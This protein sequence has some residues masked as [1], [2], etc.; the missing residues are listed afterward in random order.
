LDGLDYEVVIVDDDSDD[1]TAAAARHFAQSDSRI[2]VIQRINRRGLAV[3]LCRRNDG[4]GSQ[5]PGVMDSDLQHD[6]TIL[7]VM[8]RK[9][10]DE[11]LMSSLPAGTPGRQHGTFPGQRIALSKVGKR[12]G[13][14]VT[15]ADVSDLMSGFFVVDRRFLEE[16]VRSLSLTGFK[17]LLDMLA[18]LAGQ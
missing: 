3:G 1:G 16:V 5:L 7:P 10:K 15:H 14:L 6:E 8:L 9:L 17:I 11:K 2:R 12:V 4:V 13:R 18:T